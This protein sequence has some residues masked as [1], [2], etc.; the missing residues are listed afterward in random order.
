[1]AKR[2]QW[3]D[4]PGSL[5]D[6]ISAR[7][8]PIT[9]G[10]AIVDGQNSPLAAVVETRDGRVFVKGLPSDHRLVITQ[11]R[12]AAA[13]SLAKGISPELLWQFDEAGW[14][15]LGFEHIEGRAADYSPGSTDIDLVAG[16][17]EALAAIKVPAGPA[18]GSRSRSD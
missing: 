17:M 16:L 15:V 6:A 13:A 14:N 10:R 3:G 4:L 5:K 11:A 1:M 12:E 8:G 18:R 7:T 2:I 9:A